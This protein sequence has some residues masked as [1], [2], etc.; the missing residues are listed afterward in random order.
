MHEKEIKITRSVKIGG[1]I[2]EVGSVG[3]KKRIGPLNR[4]WALGLQEM[5]WA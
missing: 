2:S 1:A 5:G 4:C 3:I